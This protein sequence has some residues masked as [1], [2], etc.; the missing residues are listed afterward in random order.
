[1]KLEMNQQTLAWSDGLSLSSD[2]D[3][4]EVEP[5]LFMHLISLYFDYTDGGPHV[6][7]PREQFIRWITVQRN[8]TRD[9]KALLHAML[10][11]G[12]I[13]SN[14]AELAIVG[15]KLANIVRNAQDERLPPYTLQLAQTRLY[16]AMYSFARGHP[17]E[18]SEYTATAM[19]ALTALRYNTEDGLKVACHGV[20]GPFGLDPVQTIE[21]RRR[22]F[23]L[24]Y[25]LEVSACS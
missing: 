9:E 1:M 5:R 25:L 2:H 19:K 20:A 6:V 7:F 16:L 11:Y 13:F 23:W 3:P 21:C 24:A 8:K 12:S 22:T 15:D 18:T 10:A 14:N 4:Y 17:Q